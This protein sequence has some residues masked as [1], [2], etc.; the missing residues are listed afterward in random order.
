MNGS[1]TFG[2]L[3]SAAFSERFGALNIHACAT[4]IGACLILILWT[5][6]TSLAPALSFVIIFGAVSGAVIGLPPAS[7]AA[8]LGRTD[9]S[10]QAKLGQ[11]T[12]MMYSVAAV[13][14]LVGPV[15]AG[16]LLQRTDSY[17]SIQVWSGSCLALAALCMVMARMYASN[18]RGLR[19]MRDMG[20]TISRVVTR[21]KG[22]V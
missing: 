20:E 4:G 11:W 9:A 22:E 10:R 3:F 13:P 14:A 15:I 19:A 17:L 12:G 7:I 6:A 5:Q 21:E 2:R 16:A 8:I 18:G 1:S